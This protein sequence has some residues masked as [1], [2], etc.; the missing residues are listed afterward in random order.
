MWG[1]RVRAHPLLEDGGESRFIFDVDG[2]DDEL[3]VLERRSVQLAGMGRRLRLEDINGR[4][5]P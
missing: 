1:R 5:R 3:I 4:R 2:V